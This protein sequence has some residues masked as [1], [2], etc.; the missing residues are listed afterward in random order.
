MNNNNEENIDGLWTIRKLGEILEFKN[1]LNYRTGDDGEEILIV[2]VGDFKDNFLINENHLSTVRVHSISQDYLMENGDFVFVRSNGNKELIGRVLYAK[3]ITK[4]IT[5]SGF[6]IRARNKSNIVL[7]EYCATYC[8]SH[9]IK[10]QFMVKGGGSNINNLNQQLL[11]EIEINIP[12]LD[13]Q[14][15]ILKILNTCSYAIELK[16]KLIVQKKDQKQG[17]MQKLLTGEVRLPGFNDD[18]V[19]VELG[20][21]LRFLKKEPIKNPQDY[22]LLTVKLHLKGIEATDKKPNATTNGRPY[23]LRKPNELL[24]G[25]QNFHN[26]GVGIVPEHMTNYVASNAIS[27]LDTIKGEL[28]FYFYYLS[29]INFYKRL[30]HLIGGTGQKEISESMMRKLKLFIPKSDE[31]QKAIANVLEVVDKEIE[32]LE[33]E[34]LQLKLKKKGLLQLLLTGEVRV[35]V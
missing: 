33:E 16:E 21:V 12:P 34:L 2:G 15:K 35:K 13:E 29:N 32:L 1:G 22:Y 31:E 3:S 19:K 4:K 25:R 17:L 28:K 9:L 20:N 27:S 8:S 6:T 14:K 5:H 26:G 23:Y 18:W 24:I 10:R 11:S 30:E 7:N